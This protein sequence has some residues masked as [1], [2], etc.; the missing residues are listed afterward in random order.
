M[1]N[2]DPANGYE[3]FRD[4]AFYDLWA[5]RKIGVRHFSETVH[6]DSHKD[7]VAWTHDPDGI[8]PPKEYN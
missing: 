5:A 4:A 6:F 7:A 3:V 8:T 2:Q 1:A